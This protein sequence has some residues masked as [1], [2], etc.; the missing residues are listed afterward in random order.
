MRDRQTRLDARGG[1]GYLRPMH[2]IDNQGG[3]D[4]WPAR[5]VRNVRLLGRLARMVYAY[6][7]VGGRIRRAVRRC[8]REGRVFLVDEQLPPR[9]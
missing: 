7:V 9:S 5:V 1:Y 8:A 6:A 3:G 4:T 2:T